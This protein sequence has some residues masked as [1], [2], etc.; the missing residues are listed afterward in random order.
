[1][2]SPEATAVFVSAQIFSL[3]GNMQISLH[4]LP[5]IFW[6]FPELI[7]LLDSEI[8]RMAHLSRY[9]PKESEPCKKQTTL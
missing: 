8:A 3:S 6:F 4:P 7:E 9:G 2:I 1:M 5:N